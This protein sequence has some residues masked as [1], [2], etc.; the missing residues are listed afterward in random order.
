M[1]SIDV[2]PITWVWS[3][4][5]TLRHGASRQR[6]IGAAVEK[7]EA[8]HQRLI[9]ARARLRGAKET[10]QQVEAPPSTQSSAR[11]SVS[12]ASRLKRFAHIVCPASQLSWCWSTMEI[13]SAVRNSR[14]ARN[15]FSACG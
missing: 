15:S 9:G 11:C 14:R 7:L 5:P 1:P 10:D 2:W 4:L 8:L 3:A 12:W 13:S 6:N